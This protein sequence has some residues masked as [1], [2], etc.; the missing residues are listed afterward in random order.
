[1]LTIRHELSAL[2]ATA[3]AMALIGC[4]FVA[5][6]T[7]ETT[8]SASGSSTSTGCMAAQC[9]TTCQDYCDQ[10]FGGTC[11][12]FPP[13]YPSLTSCWAACSALEPTEV[14]CRAL[15]F[16]DAASACSK[17]SCFANNTLPQ[18]NSSQANFKR[19]YLAVCG[20]TLTTGV[21]IDAN[22]MS[23]L[24]LAAGPC[25]TTECLC[26]WIDL[27]ATFTDAKAACGL[28]P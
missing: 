3:I 15:Q 5:G 22:S 20:R 12:P 2:C 26:H 16:N 6:I 21:T 18:C 1:M 7:N 14:A 8:S 11:S 19:I 28:G 24:L 4:Q 23:L 25:S 27:D 13:P 10:Y 17:A 9:T